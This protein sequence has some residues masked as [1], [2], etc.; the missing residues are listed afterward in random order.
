MF[1]LV[2][3]DWCYPI[4]MVRVMFKEKGGYVDTIHC[5]N[6]GMCHTLTP[7]EESMYSKNLIQKDLNLSGSTYCARYNISF[8]DR[9]DADAKKNRHLMERIGHLVNDDGRQSNG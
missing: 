5:D 3:D 7:V 6:T 4:W 1:E 8:Q 2:D 9:N